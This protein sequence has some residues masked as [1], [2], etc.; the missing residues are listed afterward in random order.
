[1]IKLSFVGDLS[2]GEHYFSF[3]HGPRSLIERGDFIFGDVTEALHT[4]DI[5]FGNLEGPISDKD[6]DPNSPHSRVFRGSPNSV[7]QLRTAGFNVLSVANNHS[8]QHGRGALEESI[9]ALQK[10]EIT[11]VGLRSSP[12]TY[13]KTNEGEIAVIACS[14][15]P[16]NTDTDQQVYFAP[17]EQELIQTIHTAS[18][19][20]AFTIVYIHWGIEGTIHASAKQ[21]ALA[22]KL[23]A[24]GARIIVGHHTHTLQPIITSD[25]H[26]VAYSLGNFVFDLPWSYTNKESIVLEACINQHKIQDICYRRVWLEDNGKPRLTSNPIP[27]TMGEHPISQSNTQAH[28]NENIAKLGFFIKNLFQGDTK[29]KLRFLTWKLLKKLT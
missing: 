1:M 20:G 7:H 26:L 22:E 18:Q 24:A 10:A 6:Y 9:N 14:L 4:S 8:I 16:D 17:N 28:R 5:V 23:Q 27:L 2:L 13:I 29:V 21:K 12:I 11:V 19:T 3:G 25:E 15:I